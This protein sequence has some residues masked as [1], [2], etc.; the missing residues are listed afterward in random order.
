MSL[1]YELLQYLD[2]EGF[3][4]ENIDLFLGFQPNSPINCITFYDE[5]GPNM[6]ESS[7]L[8]VD[9]SSVQIL[10]RN[11]NY[12]TCENQLNEIHKKITGFGGDKEK[13][14]AGGTHINY[15]TID[16][17]PGSIGKDD[18]GNNEFSAH[19]NIRY[20]SLNDIHRI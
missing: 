19:Y 14:I 9:I 4:T 1:A 10:V 13:L 18:N 17:P 8:S 11:S 20:Q 16:V 7:D 5:P 15:I 3:G 6:A 12:F 2:N